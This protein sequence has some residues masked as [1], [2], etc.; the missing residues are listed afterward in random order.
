MFAISS[1]LPEKINF[2]R[3]PAVLL[4]LDDPFLLDYLTKQFG[5]EKVLQLKDHV[6]K[7]KKQFRGH[8]GWPIA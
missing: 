2:R 8:G 5:S 7:V 4:L 3:K 6:G 1:E